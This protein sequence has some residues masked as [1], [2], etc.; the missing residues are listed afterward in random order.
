MNLLIILIQIFL[1]ISARSFI[2][3]RKVYLKS[4]SYYFFIG[5][6]FRSKTGRTP[7]TF[8]RYQRNLF[9]FKQT[10]IFFVIYQLLLGMTYLIFFILNIME[11]PVEVLFYFILC[12]FLGLDLVKSV[13]IPLVIIATSYTRLPQLFSSDLPESQRR[14]FY[15]RR[16]SLLPR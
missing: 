11:Q 1:L 12:Y 5:L 6:K 14:Q 2:R 8:G 16:P 13:I 10:C 9:T 3:S 15:V 7:V 4:I